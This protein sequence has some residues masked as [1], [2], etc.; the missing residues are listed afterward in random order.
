MEPRRPRTIALAVVM[1]QDHLLLQPVHAPDGTLRGWRPLGGGVEYGE[2]AADAVAREVREE[3]TRHIEVVSLL[4]VSE[5]I[6]D[7]YGET[8]HEV[9]FQYVVRFADGQAPP[10]LAPLA[11]IED[12][13]GRFEACWLPLAEVVGGAY[14]IFPQGFVE[15]LGRW[16]GER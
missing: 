1:Q 3:T 4:D 6:F 2:R 10:D 5:H 13:G 7:W 14:E 15:R 9:V 8:G 12:D 11:C 16:L